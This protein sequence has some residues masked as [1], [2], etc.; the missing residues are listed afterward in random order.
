MNLLIKNISELLDIALKTTSF[1]EMLLLK[2]HSSMAI[3]RN[4][5]RNLNLNQEIID[6]LLYDPVQNVSYI[7]S[8][9]PN[10]KNLSSVVVDKI[11]TLKD[12]KYFLEQGWS[13]EQ[14]NE[15]LN[16]IGNLIVWDIPKRNIS[17]LQ[18]SNYYSKSILKDI[19]QFFLHD[20]TYD[21]YISRDRDLKQKVAEFIRGEL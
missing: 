11:I 15:V 18:K 14:F 13:N 19:Q 16:M 17:Y 2:N 10:N 20:F 5:A 21:I 12:E 7:A 9:N 4:L 6:S 8:I 3:R 1:D